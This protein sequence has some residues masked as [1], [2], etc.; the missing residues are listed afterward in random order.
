MEAKEYH[1]VAPKKINEVSVNLPEPQEKNYLIRVT[2]AQ[3]CDADAKYYF[4]LRPKIY[5]IFGFDYFYGIR[6]KQGFMNKYPLLLLHEA[7]GVIERAGPGTLLRPGTRVVLIPSRRCDNPGC[8][9][10]SK[11][12]E[13][14]CKRS[15]FMSSNAPGFARTRIIQPEECVAEI[16]DN[17]PNE[18]AVHTEMSTVAYG[19]LVDSGIEEGDTVAVFGDGY[20]G[21]ILSVIAS[22]AF[23]IPKERL[24]VFGRHDSK[25]ERFSGFTTTINLNKE[26]IPEQLH[27][28]ANRIFEC[29]G[30]RSAEKIINTSISMIR[31][32]GTIMLLGVSEEM[33]QINT[34]DILSKAITIRGLSRSPARHYPVILDFMKDQE[35]QKLYAKVAGERLAVK[36]V[37]DMKKAFEEYM[38]N[39][40]KMLLDFSA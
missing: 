38:I 16:P 31:P 2:H 15:K 12:N 8:E 25:L 7:V 5:S 21:Y 30:K 18:I 36:S 10:C 33:V 37:N 23:H 40:S 17:V 1:V 3:V 26:K 29:V 35:I 24:Y 27:N 28:K 6:D 9:F 4:G 19:A 39:R 22:K 34:R 14:S 11:G 20:L 32:R 13:N